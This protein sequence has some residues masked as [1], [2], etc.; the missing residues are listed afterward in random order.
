MLGQ[1]ARGGMSVI[2]KGHDTDLGRDVAVKVLDEELA[3][4]P[5]VV[6]RFIEEAQI[7][8]QLQHPGIVPVYEL[9]L[10]GDAR[11]YFTMKLVKGRTLASLFGQRKAVTD[12]RGRL[13][14]IFEAVCQTVA[15]AHSK[16]VVHRDLK[17]AN[18]MV[19]AFG[20]VQV[21][22]WGLAKV[23]GQGG[24]AD[25]QR[26]KETHAS[27]HTV[28][29]TIRSGPGSSGSDSMVGSVM[30]TPAYMA[31]E[32]AQ[33]EI[34]KLDERADVFSLGAILC[35]L[36]TGAPPYDEHADEP[37][38]VQAARAMLDPARER[39]RASGADPAL[40]QLCLDCLSPARAA[41]PANADAVA[42]AVHDF[43]TSSEERA[44]RAEL[45][46]A[47]QRIQVAE[48]RRARRLMAALGAAILVALGVGGG[49]YLWVERTQA[50][51][52]EATRTAVEEAQAEALALGQGDRPGEAL[53]AARR[54]QSL[55]R[56]G[57]ADAALL[58]RVERFVARAEADLEAA[59]R[60]EE[61]ELKDEDLRRRLV[62]LRLGQIDTIGNLQRERELDR[63]FADAFREYGVDLEAADLTPA[64]ARIRERDIAEEVAL[65][66]D[67]WSRLRRKLHGHGS[68]EADNLFFLAMDLDPDPVRMEMREAIREGRR[69]ALLS[70]ARP[71]TLDRM[72]AGS[73]FVLSSAIWD[74]Y[75]ED[76]DVV[77][78]SY[79][80][81]LPFHPDDYVLQSVGGMI[82]LR[83]GR[84]EVS[85][86]CRTAALSQ[87]P[88]DIG[89]RKQ[90]AAGLLFRGRLE[91]FGDPAGTGWLLES[92]A[93]A[94]L[95]DWEAAER[96]LRGRYELTGVAL[97]VPPVLSFVRA[98]V[99]A[100]L[101]QLDSARE[102]NARGLYEASELMRDD[103]ESWRRSDLVRW[104]E[105]AARALGN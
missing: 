89:A 47:E 40:V 36:L 99:F 69:D 85:L 54:A 60:A 80:R 79:D 90:L 19:G 5:D 10:M 44:Q 48:E 2:L 70:L 62:E 33:G 55:A 86:A 26:A 49:S 20:E 16:G 39:I 31:P 1:I 95:E 6:Q 28:I 82:Y 97:L 100:E 22:D 91:R 42:T 52:R 12:D 63:E 32:Q 46:A 17:P 78:R 18:I 56:A 76:R 102:A 103:E 8:G 83:S 37:V 29:E 15:Y 4:R 98:V 13:L 43:L 67:D 50:E 94:L 25:E 24:V 7:G 65:A 30:G 73:V 35:E 59:E 96:S 87:R 11:P 88:D 41:R 84:H 61:L 71:E 81:A 9:G 27:V 68:E 58:D 101:G 34:E 75:P 14:A 105:R 104:R 51:R 93:F 66:L 72:S 21:V 23:L 77:Y 92:L 64:L 53:A 45:E 57:Q 74:M 38:V 3:K